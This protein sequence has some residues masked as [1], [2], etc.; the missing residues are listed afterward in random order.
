MSSALPLLTSR[1]IKAARRLVEA[2]Q[3]RFETPFDDLIGIHE[4][5]RLVATAARSGFVLKMFAIDEAHQGWA[6]LGELAS[7]LVRLG[8]AAGH[9]VFF[10]FTRPEHASAFEQLN[11]RLLAAHG[12]VALLEYGGGLEAYL[13]ANAHLRRPGRSGAVVVNGNPF[14]LGHLYLVETAARQV[15]TLYLFVVTEDRSVF[16]FV[17]RYRLAQES[18]AHVPNVVVLETSRYA[19]SA[20]TFPSY[21]L[22][23]RDAAA[24]SQMQ[25]D[26]RLFGAHLA[27]AFGVTARFVGQE[28]YCETTAAYNQVMAEVLPEYGVALVEIP[29]RR[30][31]GGFISATRVREALARGDLD[32]L[33]T[34]VPAPTL[35]FL[36]SPEGASI[37][38]KLASSPRGPER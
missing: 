3:L 6:V 26:L 10:V 34:L 35:A 8:H 21:F 18:T 11:F 33:A 30:D 20:A 2:Q 38:G 15:D 28:P 22:K 16:P 14:T 24:L 19:V 7:A 5:G 29:R 17:V 25:L 13:A 27:P 31:D 32:T 12:P 4:D 36:R 1:D 9:E 23:Q 37:A